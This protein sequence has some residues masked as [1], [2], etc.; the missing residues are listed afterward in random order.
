MTAWFSGGDLSF[1]EGADDAD[2]GVISFEELGAAAARE[3]PL[4]ALPYLS[5]SIAAAVASEP[6]P[7]DAVSGIEHKCV[8]VGCTAPA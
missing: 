4:S 8:T 2:D 6:T 5:F 1:G 3:P 7:A